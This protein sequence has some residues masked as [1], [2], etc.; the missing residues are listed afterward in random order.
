MDELK[1]NVFDARKLLAKSRGLDPEKAPEM[2]K[3]RIRVRSGGQILDNEELQPN[4]LHLT[5]DEMEVWYEVLKFAPD[6]YIEAADKFAL[7]MLCRLL[8]KSRSRSLMSAKESD[9]LIQLMG[10]FGLTPMDR[11]RVKKPGAGKNKTE[12]NPF[13]DL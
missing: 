11:G 9:H 7:E 5:P 1:S 8:A 12:R 3:R 4:P 2:Q 6:G 10:K 13:D